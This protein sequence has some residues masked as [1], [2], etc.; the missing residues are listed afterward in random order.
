MSPFGRLWYEVAARICENWC[1]HVLRNL[2]VDRWSR[3]ESVSLNHC[4]IL[5]A[6][7]DSEIDIEGVFECT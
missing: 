2:N 4:V 5:K 3:I 6:L 7:M 1:I